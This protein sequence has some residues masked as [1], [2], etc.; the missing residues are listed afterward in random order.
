MK[1]RTAIILLLLLH[2]VMPLLSQ[3]AE[4]F[5]MSDIVRLSQEHSISAHVNRNSFSAAY[6]NYRSYQAGLRPSVTL[7]AG[8]GQF[9]RSLVALQ[10]YDTGEIGYRANCNMANEATL[11]VSQ[12]I[13]LTGGTL[14]LSSSLS[15]LDQ[16]GAARLGSWY[17]QP[18]YLSYLQS[19]WGYNGFK[20]S[21]RTEP[22][23]YEKAKREY[24]ENMESVSMN[25]VRLFWNCIAARENCNRAVES[26]EE[27][28]SLYKVSLA[29]FET[30]N[31]SL[32]NLLQLELR[33]L[34]DSLAMGSA[35]VAL[36][37]AE[38]MICSFIGLNEDMHVELVDDYEI[39][40]LELDSHDVLE[41]ALENSSFRL[42]QELDAIEADRSVAQAKAA[43]GIQAALNARLGLTSTSECLSAAAAS[44]QDQEVVGIS[45]SIP[46]ADWGMAAGRLRMARAQAETVRLQQE[47]RMWDYRQNIVS[48]VMQFNEQQN[49]CAISKRAASVALES[50]RK[51]FTQFSQGRIS[52]IELNQYRSV[53]DN[54]QAE[55]ISQVAAFW[56]AYFE[57]R[58]ATLYDYLSGTD[59]SVEFDRLTE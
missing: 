24:L 45:V 32:D 39:P 15:R 2:P 13:G 51:A 57:I 18:V 12:N 29:R 23:R 26:Y 4:G 16:Y 7:D 3:N 27:S 49:R 42:E 52:V 25:A 21:R 17:V 8:L 34:N 41:R 56:N 11:S 46:I 59:I 38:N 5:T 37:T 20:W 31:I 10:D 19:L 33:V 28:S 58:A 35:Q 14:S 36:R 30:G 53:S 6:W 22:E 40:V 44:L 48:M 1:K 9:N 43:K 47:Q 50:Y 55:Y 54:A